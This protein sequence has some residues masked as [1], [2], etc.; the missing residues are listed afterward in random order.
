MFIFWLI[1]I[2]F[3]AVWFSMSVNV[4]REDERL[5]VFRLGR[6]MGLK[7]PGLIFII[8]V[9]DRGVRVKI[10]PQTAASLPMNLTTIDNQALTL[11]ARIVYEVTDPVKAVSKGPSYVAGT[12]LNIYETLKG[13]V[14]SMSKN[15]V[16]GR[17]RELGEEAKL[18]VG[19]QLESWGIKIHKLE[20]SEKGA[21]PAAPTAPGA[22]PWLPES[23]KPAAKDEHGYTKSER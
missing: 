6:L 19:V 14:G 1:I 20:V 8:P 23:A 18:Q 13:I 12:I 15:E 2:I 16:L 10:G 5:V 21:G 3:A 4:V 11:Q 22:A 17:S 7:G 9:V